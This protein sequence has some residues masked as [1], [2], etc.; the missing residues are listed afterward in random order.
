M[1]R[2]LDATGR[3]VDRPTG[4]MAIPLDVAGVSPNELANFVPGS[5]HALAARTARSGGLIGTTES[6]LRQIGV[7]GVLE[8]GA[9]DDVK[10][11]GVVPDAAIGGHEVMVSQQEA[12]LLGISAPRY[13][14]V[15][16]KPGTAWRTVGR[17]IHALVP[18]G[19]PV[20]IRGPGEAM[21]LREADAVL[22]PVIMKSVFGEFAASPQV[23]AD[24]ALSLDPSWERSHIVSATVPILGTV[25]C[26]R[27]LIPLL[28][29][30]L[31]EVQ[32]RGLTSLVHPD[33]YGG[34]FNARLIRGSAEDISTHTWGAAIDL[35]VAENPFG[36]TPH[37]DPRLVA[38]FARWGFAWGGRFLIPDGMHFQFQCVPHGMNDPPGPRCHGRAE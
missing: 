34:C 5:D 7:G 26:N 15:E 23:P 21:Y 37:Q 30:A 27:I 13:L 11:V 19:T 38:I 20:R 31:G 22:P 4:G 12:D 2:S 16:P 36:G 17:A 25:R 35:N 18:A 33:E 3:T 29:G 1:T 28:R 8:F 32:A 9:A 6:R 14:L 10:V 24:G